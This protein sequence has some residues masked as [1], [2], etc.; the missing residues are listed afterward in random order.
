MTLNQIVIKIREF[1]VAHKSLNGRFFEGSLFEYCCDK[2][3]PY[4]VLTMTV[5]PSTITQGIK[6]YSA[7]FGVWDRVEL[8]FSNRLEVQSDTELIC[9]DLIAFIRNIDE[10]E[11]ELPISIDHHEEKFDDAVAGSFFTG[12]ID[13]FHNINYCGIP[14]DNDIIVLGNE[15]EEAITTD[16]NKFILIN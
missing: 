15:D 14:L 11:I 16:D 7:Q 9:Q 8:D 2:S 12:V 1:S 5:L 10:F 3:Q 13:Q 6:T 4:P